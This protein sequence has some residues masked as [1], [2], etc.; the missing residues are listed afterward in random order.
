LGGLAAAAEER[1]RAA[2]A[3]A[4]FNAVVVLQQKASAG[5]GRTQKLEGELH[6][7]QQKLEEVEVRRR[8]QVAAAELRREGAEQRERQVKQQ[9]EAAKKQLQEAERAVEDVVVCQICMDRKKGTVIMPCMHFLYCSQCLQQH[10]GP[11]AGRGGTGGG[12]GG[13]RELV[14][15]CPAC[16]GRVTGQL[17]VRLHT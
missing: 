5:L 13:G 3:L 14:E 17:M 10:R 6:R 4:R 9:L 11:G 2:Q 7:L 8:E 1:A 12:S 15:Q 16:R